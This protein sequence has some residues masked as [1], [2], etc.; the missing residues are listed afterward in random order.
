VYII[1][2]SDNTKLYKITASATKSTIKDVKKPAILIAVSLVK[3][4]GLVISCQ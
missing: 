3:G 1:S 4:S 2:N